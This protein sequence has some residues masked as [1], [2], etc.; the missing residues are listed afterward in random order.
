MLSAV[1]N[2]STTRKQIKCIQTS[3]FKPIFIEK[4]NFAFIV[5]INSTNIIYTKPGGR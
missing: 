1:H 5:A 4:A 3:K 2:I